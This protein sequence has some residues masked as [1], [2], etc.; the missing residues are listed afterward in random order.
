MDKKKSSS[1]LFQQSIKN[2]LC[3]EQWDNLIVEKIICIRKER[4]LKW[5]Q[6]GIIPGIIL[7]TTSL[8]YFSNGY[9]TKSTHFAKVENHTKGLKKNSPSNEA[10]VNFKLHIV[11]AVFNRLQ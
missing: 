9:F 4:Q 6:L 1:E 2:K 3:D 8:I 10:K 5:I 11:D 7:T